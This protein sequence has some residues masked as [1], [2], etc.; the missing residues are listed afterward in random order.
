M[1]EKDCGHSHDDRKKLVRLILNAVGGLIIV[2]LLI[3][4]LF[5]AIT[6]PS[7]PSFILQD[8]TLYAFNLS[9]GP[10]PPNALTTNLQVTITTRNPNDKIGIY[11]QKADVY[12]SYRN[13][14]I[15]LATLLPATY[16][17]HKDV[18][19]WSPFLYGNSVPVSP[20]VAESLGQDLN[21]GM[22]MVNIKVDGR[23]KWK[24]GTWISGRYH[25]HVN[26]P[27]YITFGDKS[28]GIASG[29]SLKF[30]LVQSCSVD[31]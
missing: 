23:I 27:A 25:L 12:A 15:S 20:F 7:K 2:V 9:T 28:K 24:V 22:V 30:Q 13:Q 8:A 14:Q 4:F 31:V 1:S 3:I 18:I 11:Y 29:A 5:W 26:C 19:V 16:Q 17:G 10:S 21:A 6:R